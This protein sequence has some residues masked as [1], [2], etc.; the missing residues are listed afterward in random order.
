MIV[1]EAGYQILRPQV[2][3]E[4]SRQAML[5]II[6]QA[7]RVCYKSEDLIF[8]GSASLMVRNLVK[9]NHLAMLEHASM[10]VLWTV[11]IAVGR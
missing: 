2:M 9:R 6:E 3:D 4:N 11:D 7:A 10:T 5:R 8:D 1:K